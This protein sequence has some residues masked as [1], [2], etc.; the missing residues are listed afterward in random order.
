[1][2]EGP[3]IQEIAHAI[4]PARPVVFL[5]ELTG[6]P[7]VKSWRSGRRRAPLSV[8]TRLRDEAEFRKLHSLVQQFDYLIRRRS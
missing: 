6:R 7:T 1:M 3:W 5:V 8:L 4:N 2:Q